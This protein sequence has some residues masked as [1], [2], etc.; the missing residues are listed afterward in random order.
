ME[1]Y[2][3]S[4]GFGVLTVWTEGRYREKSSAVLPRRV[5][6]LASSLP[7]GGDRRVPADRHSA[8]VGVAYRKAADS[9]PPGPVG[10]AIQATKAVI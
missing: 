10:W 4:D 2:D 1:G 8:L 9:V 7:E 3:C 6:E 5:R